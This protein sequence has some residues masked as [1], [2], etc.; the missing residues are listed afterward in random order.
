MKTYKSTI[1]ADS[2]CALDM[3]PSFDILISEEDFNLLLQSGKICRPA[4]DRTGMNSNANFARALSWI[5]NS[6]CAM[7]TAWRQKDGEEKVTRKV[8]EENNRQLVQCLREFGYG[9]IK[10]LGWFQ[11]EGDQLAKEYSF[12]VFN[13]RNDGSPFFQ[14]MKE[15]AERFNQ[16]SFLYKKPGAKEQIYEYCIRKQ[17]STPIGFINF[18]CVDPMNHSMIGGHPF[19]FSFAAED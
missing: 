3:I 4:E 14:R 11:E 18:E 6:E 17:S 7:I 1:F 19:V 9:V 12:L 5:T 8:N 10:S 13:H 15:L 16:D 2:N